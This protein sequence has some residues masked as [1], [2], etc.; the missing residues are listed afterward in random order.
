MQAVSGAFLSTEWDDASAARF[1]PAR[2]GQAR[3]LVSRRHRRLLVPYQRPHPSFRLANADITK[4]KRVDGRRDLWEMTVAPDS[5]QAVTIRLPETR[6]CAASGAVC[7]SDKRPL[8]HSLSATV[9]GPVG[10]SVADARVEEDKDAVLTFVVTLD[11]AA[12]GTVTVDYATENGS[13]TAGQDYTATSGTLRF[14]AGDTAKTIEVAVLD[15]SHDEG[16][17]TLTLRL[18]NPS[19]GRL[20]DAEATGTIEN[21]DP[22]PRALLARFGRTV[23]VQVV[24]QVEER[25]RAPRQKG[26]RGQFA[27]REL[28]RGMVREMGVDFLNRLGGLAGAN[29]YGAGLDTPMAGSPAGGAAMPGTPGPS[30]G[31][32]GMAAAGPMMGAGAGPGPDGV[33]NG[34]GRLDMGFGGG[35]ILTGSGFVLNHETGR[36]GILSFWSRGEQSQFHGREGDLALDGRV[37]TSMFGADYA[38]GPLVAGLSLAHSRGRGGYSGVGAGEVTSSVTGLY[39]WLGYKASDRI[40]LWGVTGYGKGAL[41][42]TPGEATTLRS[43]LSMAMVAGGLRGD[44]AD[45]VVGGFGL[46]F[47]ADALWVGTGIKG[48]DGP[49]GRLA[50]TEATVTRL[51]TGLE[52]SRGYSIKRRLS[53]EPS[54]EVGLRRDG[55]D[56][57]TGAGVDIG[58]GLVVLDPLSGLSADVRVRMLLVHQD[59]GFRER[60]VSVSFSYD[61]TPRTPLGFLAKVSPS[62]GGQATSGAEAMWGRETMAEMAHGGASAGNRLKAELG[63]GLPVGSRFIGAP[64]FGIA[65][66]EYGR[67]Y[68]LGYGLRVFESGAMNF[69]L[70]VDAQRHVSPGQE[71]AEHGVAGQLTVRW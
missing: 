26:F 59:A 29:R 67:D 13:A 18:S 16:E 33:P 39:P 32:L 50:A 35:N 46:A 44:L 51:R 58:G 10:I 45:S 21:R 56:A 48:V 19:G 5:D 12:G 22:L 27:G 71:G 68:R 6:D 1:V 52:A 49:G 69:D 37:R 15:D 14:E 43:G 30:G 38:T 25:I 7:T 42:L 17:E 60:G 24:E 61:P 55:G 63:Y 41:R 2:S 66:S 65:T 64:R 40:T 53:L 31:G 70:G 20:V 54:L 62:W 11:R 36:G 57:E 9:T 8:S 3:T 47:K 28:R 4:A 23:A 34:S